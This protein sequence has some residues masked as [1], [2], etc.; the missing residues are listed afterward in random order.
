MERSGWMIDIHSHILPGLDDGAQTEEDSIEM[1]KQAVEQGIH[2]VIATPHHKNRHY[3]NARESIIKHTNILNELFTTHGIPLT[4]LPGQE[5]RINGDMIAGLNN[6][7]LL[8]L[9]DTKYLFVEF[10]F[11]SVPRYAE[12]ML[13]DLQMEGYIPIIVHP[14]RNSEL[15]E[16]PDRLY[17]F[18]RRGALT[19][20]TAGSLVGHYGKKIQK[21][22]EQIVETHLTH[23][24]ASDAHN[25]KTR[26]FSLAEAYQYIDD[27]YGIDTYYMFLE[28]SELLIENM[29]VNRVEPEKIRRRK[30]LGFF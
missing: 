14:E 17:S 13:Y 29:N 23:F 25:V 20:I 8:P 30:F 21:F 28:N 7:E 15:M 18:V 11:G 22:T 4:L 26:P 9:N 1:A 6:N 5:V 27:N 3:E 19:Q 2:T 12:R 10:P 16:S 24:V